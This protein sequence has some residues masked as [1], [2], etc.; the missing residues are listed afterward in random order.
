MNLVVYFYVTHVVEGVCTLVALV[1]HGYRVLA[2]TCGNDSTV[3]GVVV[4]GRTVTTPLVVSAEVLIKWVVA[5][6][7]LCRIETDCLADGTCVGVTVMR[8]HKLT[9]DIELQMILQE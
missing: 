4:V 6:D 8:I 3:D 2:R 1:D 9:V 5:H 7:R